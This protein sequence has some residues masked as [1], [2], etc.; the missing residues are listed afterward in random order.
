MPAHSI[1]DTSA[2]SI[3]NEDSTDLKDVRF[4]PRFFAAS[5]VVSLL[6]DR[7]QDV[8]TKDLLKDC[9]STI[10]GPANKQV[11]ELQIHTYSLRAPTHALAYTYKNTNKRESKIGQ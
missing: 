5:Q 9:K 4:E 8:A 2:C 11:C 10:L 3:H 1:Q 6:F 7:Q